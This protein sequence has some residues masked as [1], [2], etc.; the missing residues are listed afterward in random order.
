MAIFAA[1][2][3]VHVCVHVFKCASVFVRELLA[4]NRAANVGGRLLL[5]SWV[6]HGDNQSRKL[7]KNKTKQRGNNEDHHHPKNHEWRLKR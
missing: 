1:L 7:L 6:L 3:G 4:P 5:N 2:G